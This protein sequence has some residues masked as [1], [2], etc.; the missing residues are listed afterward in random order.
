MPPIGDRMLENSIKVL[1]RSHSVQMLVKAV[2]AQL[3]LPLEEILVITFKV[4][5]QDVR[6]LLEIWLVTLTNNHFQLPLVIML[7]YPIKEKEI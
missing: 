4:V 1:L 3:Q 7:V 6:L 5:S 2:K